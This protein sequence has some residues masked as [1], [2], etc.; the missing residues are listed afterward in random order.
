[1]CTIEDMMNANCE[2]CGRNRNVRNYK[3]KK[4]LCGMH[5]EQMRRFG[6]I[7]PRTL[8]NSNDYIE[9]EDHYEMVIYGRDLKEKAR[10]LIDKEDKPLIE[11][12]GSWCLDSGGY[13]MNG[14]V[15]MA[16]HRFLLGKKDGLEI[17]HIDGNKLD[18]RRSNL[19]FVTHRENGK[20]WINNFKRKV[21]S[22][23]Q[24][25]LSEG[26]DIESFFANL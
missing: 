18:N 8:S 23:F 3:G 21:I 12:V 15:K 22:D 17:D 13:V 10:A 19:R 6:R 4:L 16:V 5:R 24:A 9:K 2:I 20:N 11:K 7:R 26:K 1:M 14:S 25:H